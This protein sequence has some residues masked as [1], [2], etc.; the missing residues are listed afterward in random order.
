MLETSLC[1]KTTCFYL[2]TGSSISLLIE[3]QWLLTTISFFLVGGEFFW[4][5]PLRLWHTRARTP[6][7]K[8]EGNKESKKERAEWSTRLT[9][10]TRTVLPLTEQEQEQERERV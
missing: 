10:A 1:C 4:C 7:R 9:C 5:L 3:N 6:E 2:D 8:T